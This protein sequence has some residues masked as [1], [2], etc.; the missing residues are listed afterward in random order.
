MKPPIVSGKRVAE[1]KLAT[2]VLVY[3]ANHGDHYATLHPVT[4]A[5]GRATIGAGQPLTESALRST[6]RDLGA[7]KGIGGWLPAD[8]LYMDDTTIV[9]TRRPAPR[10]VFFTPHSGVGVASATIYHPRLVFAVSRAGWYVAAVPKVVRTE[11]ATERRVALVGDGRPHL[12]C[13]LAHAPYFN[14]YESGSICVGNATLPE[15]MAADTLQGYE[16]AFFDSKFTH[17]NNPHMTAHP[18]GP[19]ALWRELVAPRWEC[20][21]SPKARQCEGNINFRTDGH[22][23]QRLNLTPEFP[24]QHLTPMNLTLDQWVGRIVKGRT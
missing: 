19:V 2:A 18:D 24:E 15:R 13:P 17:S 21:H 11:S 3:K 14:V 16:D 4:H 9:W 12:D 7:P 6:L 10:A 8:V 23:C 1:Y 5:A 20:H 22:T